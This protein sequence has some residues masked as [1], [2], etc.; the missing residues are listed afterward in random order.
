[1]IC[2][3]STCVKRLATVIVV[4]LGVV[5]PASHAYANGPHGGSEEVFSGTVGPYEIKALAPPIVGDM[6][7]AVFVSPQGSTAAVTDATVRLSGRG[8]DGAVGPLDTTLSL[9]NWYGANI[10]VDAAGEWEFTVSVD[11]SLGEATVDF[12]M[13]IVQPSGFSWTATG[14]A[15]A[16]LAAATGIGIVLRQRMTRR[17]SRQGRGR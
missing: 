16:V 1:M 12:P 13:V 3:S 5:L 8:P 9:T 10:A 17:T 6:Y 11:S 15:A 7:L 2:A 14:L 4:L